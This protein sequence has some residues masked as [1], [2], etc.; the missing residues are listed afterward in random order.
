MKSRIYMIVGWPQQFFLDILDLPG[1]RLKEVILLQ[2]LYI[3]ESPGEEITDLKGR[4]T[5]SQEG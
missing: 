5:V 4:G 1:H 3:Y 2:K